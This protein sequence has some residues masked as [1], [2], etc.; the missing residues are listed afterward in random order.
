M[1]VG[2][3]EMGPESS[4]SVCVCVCVCVSYIQDINAMEFRFQ[5]KLKPRSYA[6]LLSKSLHVSQSATSQLSGHTTHNL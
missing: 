1:Y 5:D 4:V 2:N 3:L 6:L